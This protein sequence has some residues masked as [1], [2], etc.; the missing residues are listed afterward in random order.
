MRSFDAPTL[1]SE[2]GLPLEV[3]L[4]R[5]EISSAP[6]VR[7]W[8]VRFVTCVQD[9]LK[10]RRKAELQTIHQFWYPGES[11]LN[12][13]DELERRVAQALT[14][15]VDLNDRIARLTKT[16]RSLLTALLE[17]RPS[18]EA[19]VKA[20]QNRLE[21]GGA[22]KLEIESAARMLV[23]RGFIDRKRDTPGGGSN[24]ELFAIPSELA[25]QLA[26][27]LDLGD[28]RVAPEHQL[29]QQRLPFEADIEG[30]QL[31]LIVGNLA[32]PV[33]RKIVEL[34]I[35]ERGIAE[36]TN[37]RLVE[38]LETH[39][40]ELTNPE[41]K[42]T[43]EETGIGTIGP[44]S[45]EDFAIQ[46]EQPAVIVFQE[47]M[48]Q[49]YRYQLDRTREPDTVVEA[50]VDLYIDVDRISSHFDAN[51]GRLTRTGRIPKRLHESLRSRLCLPR[52]ESFVEGD[53][54]DTGLRMSQRLGIVESY[55]GEI[56]VDTERLQRWRGLD[57][58][59]QV[60]VM[61]DRFLKDN[62][63]A[64]WT[65]HQEFL[66][67]ILVETLSTVDPNGWIAFDSLVGL[68]VSTYML[69]LEE[70]EVRAA[71]R[72]RREEDFSRERLNSP[73][74]RLASDLSHWI[75]HCFLPLGV[76]ELG[77]TGG[78]LTTFRLT[79]LGR[80]VFG[81]ENV[82]G[83]SRVLVNPDFEIMLFCEGLPGLRLELEL[84][85][86][87]ERVSAERVRRYRVTRESIRE[88]IRAGLSIDEIERHLSEASDYPLPEPVKV[89]LRDW[90]KDLDWIHLQPAIVLGGLDPARRETIEKLLNA[91]QIQFLSASDGSLI[92]TGC[93]QDLTELLQEEGWL[94]R[95]QQ[96]AIPALTL[97]EPSSE[98]SR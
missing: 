35:A 56:R 29:S 33:L 43:L 12:T 22:A 93:D 31:H 6:I 62:Q 57:L 63:S 64:R 11:R 94:V 67:S 4:Q 30:S 87:G 71:L 58:L 90:G 28:G 77:L 95:V 9:V 54:T 1:Q 32:D 68:S 19:A 2:E 23:E 55:M 59:Q 5:E 75:V 7:A 36:S 20:V 38:L 97:E 89:D 86:F 14:G 40:R 81:L 21:T 41:W 76:C 78:K 80:E 88:G 42:K 17:Q 45:L 47:W 49:Y 46:I 26:D 69:E 91:H 72:E 37:P 74:S 52:L 82:D 10:R 96:S 83:E 53:M 61:L 65:F 48:E 25:P 24:Q 18:Y 60:E 3:G 84:S 39:D 27:A 50:G 15:G 92:I 66:R 79:S 98:A 16:Q 70:R 34:A 13:R 44:I 73:F 85:R 8:E 51:P